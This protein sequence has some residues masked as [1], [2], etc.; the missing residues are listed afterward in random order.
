MLGTKFGANG[1]KTVGDITGE[2]YARAT[3]FVKANGR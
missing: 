2:L 3:L 1:S